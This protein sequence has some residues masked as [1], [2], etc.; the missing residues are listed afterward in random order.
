[1]SFID[2]IFEIF[3]NYLRFTP[4]EY[5]IVKEKFQIDFDRNKENRIIKILNSP[6]MMFAYSVLLPVAR[7]NLE[8]LLKWAIGDRDQ[9]G[10]I[11]KVDVLLKL[12]SLIG[13]DA[14]NLQ[15][16]QRDE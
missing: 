9:D 7:V 4:D 10:D 2:F 5:A 11:D 15:T 12:A 16:L 6:Y 8:K 13:V 3:K 1:M 14:R